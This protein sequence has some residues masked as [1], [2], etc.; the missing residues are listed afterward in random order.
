[1]VHAAKHAKVDEVSVYA[2]VIQHG[3]T[4]SLEVFVRDRGVGFDPS[5]IA[6]DRH[7]VADSIRSHGARRWTCGRALQ[8]DRRGHQVQL[9]VALGDGA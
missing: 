7:G 3:T 9:E 6:A 5:V 2:E 1:M 8:R 4:R